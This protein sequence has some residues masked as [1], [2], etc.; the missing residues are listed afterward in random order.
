M[1]NDRDRDQGCVLD[2]DGDLDL[3]FG[4]ADGGICAPAGILAGGI[5]AG[6]YP[7]PERLDLALICAQGDAPCAAGMFTTNTFCAAPVQ[8]SREHVA[9]GRCRA[10]VL[11]A[12]NANA[13]TG[14]LGLEAARA[15]TDLVAS[16]LGITADEVL[17]AST[18]VIGVPLDL[19]PIER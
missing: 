17:V 11:N 15:T 10:I 13:A 1:G 2:G 14:E 19:Q 3:I 18:G 16:A 4:E 8:V 12:G 5:H 9:D 7:D 6:M